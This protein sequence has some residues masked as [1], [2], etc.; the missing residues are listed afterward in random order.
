MSEIVKQIKPTPLDEYPEP[1]EPVDGQRD[2][3][4]SEHDRNPGLKNGTGQN[5]FPRHFKMEDG[6]EAEQC[7]PEGEGCQKHE[8]RSGNE[9]SILSKCEEEN[10][11]G[12]GQE[13]HD[14]EKGRLFDVESIVVRNRPA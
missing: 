1:A 3:D 5:S 8:A 4:E 12:H 11:G 9:T 6:V 13:T 10:R 2:E 7:Y 14:Q